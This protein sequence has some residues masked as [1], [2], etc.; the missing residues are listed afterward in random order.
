MCNSKG[1]IF[2]QKQ[3][4]KQ[5]LHFFIRYEEEEEEEKGRKEGN[6]PY[7]LCFVYRS[8][9]YDS[10]ETLVFTWE[11]GGRIKWIVLKQWA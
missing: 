4:F 6:L 5:I 10:Q 1:C 8:T 7:Y 2:R 3:I 9:L 11:I